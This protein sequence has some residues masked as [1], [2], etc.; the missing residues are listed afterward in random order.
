MNNEVRSL[1]AI[2]NDVYAG[3]FFTT[4]GG[5]PAYG[6]A[7]WTGS[8]WLPVGGGVGGS[9]RQLVLF[10]NELYVAGSFLRVTNYDGSAIAANNIAKWNGANWS[11]L[12]LGTDSTVFALAASGDYLYAGGAFT[13]A[14]GSPA[15]HVAK[16]DGAAWSALGAGINGFYGY[17][18]ALAVSGSDMYAG[19]DFTYAGGTG[20]QWDARFIAK[21]DGNSWFALGA[22]TRNGVDNTVYALSVSGTNLFSGGYFLTAGGQ[23]TPYFART[24][25][26]A[27]RGRFS[28]PTYSIATGFQCTFS[29]AS[30]GQPYRIQSASSLSPAIWTDITNISYASPVVIVDPSPSVGTLKYF[31]AVSP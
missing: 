17:V 7:R 6:I 31:R 12:G 18:Y 4:A 19:G 9:V 23:P 2:S 30:V 29:D 14:G 13:S 28:N 20:Y 3:G 24:T 10:R 21:W 16:W 5:S 11:A 15:N 27:A 25:I 1:V 26:A 22:P 8:A